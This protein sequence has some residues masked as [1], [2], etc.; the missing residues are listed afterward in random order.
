MQRL[1]A[2]QSAQIERLTERL[3]WYKRQVFGPK[4]EKLPPL[5]TE[6]GALFERTAPVA[7]D[8]QN[9]FTHVPAHKRRKHRTGDE[10]NDTGLRLDASVPR[11]IIQLSCAELRGPNAAEYEIVST[12]ISQRLARQPGSHVVL[13]YERPVVRH[14]GS[15]KL[16]TTPAPLGVLDHAQ[17][18]VTVLAGLLIDKFTYHT[19]LY[20]QHQRLLDEGVTVSRQTLLNWASRAIGLLEPIAHCQRGMIISGAHLKIDETPIKAGRTKTASGQGK[21]KQGW[22]WP[23]LGEHGDIAF[24]YSPGRGLNVVKEALGEHF[25]GTI[26]TDGYKVYASYAKELPKCIHALCWAHT[27]RAI[28]KAEASEPERTKTLL[29][30]IQALYRVEKELRERGAGEH[31]IL[32]TRARD[33]EPIIDAF[34]ERAHRMIADPSLLPKSPLAKALKYAKE[35]EQGLRVFL[36]DAW[37]APDTNDLERALRVVPMGRKNW[38]FCSTEMGA[39]QVAT[40]QTLLASCRAHG[41]DPYT[42]LVDVLQRVQNHPASAVGELTPRVWK[43]TFAGDP[44]RSDLDRVTR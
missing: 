33:T 25:E 41:V 6:Q 13:Q 9:N 38:L 34:F 24:L 2:E 39:E 1:V 29:E 18:D 10:V 16:T 35:R 19:P 7:P 14:K 22:M 3:D 17:V 12:K 30:P 44:L 42:Y 43:E 37:L 32:T 31:D 8:D 20:R 4:S 28:L 36:T 27:R 11:K 26:Q 5:D 40:I 23:M 21:M 15:G